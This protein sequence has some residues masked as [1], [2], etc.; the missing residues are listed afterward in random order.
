[1]ARSR[2]TGFTLLEVLVA[3]S[4]LAALSLALTQAMAA[5]H[6][7]TYAALEQAR[8]ITLVE[9]MHEEIAAQPFPSNPLAVLPLPA[10]R[11]L[12][13]DLKAYDNLTEIPGALADHHGNLLPET[14]QGFTRSVLIAENA[15]CTINDLGV[16]L[17]GIEV[18]VT[19]ALPN[20][21]SWSTTRFIPNPTGAL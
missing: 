5:G 20:G 16:T 18:T 12:I 15:T 3:M 6:M 8:A 13:T 4:I 19:V 7:Q 10:I 14:Y 1:M 9:S 2:R 11:S 21:Q 17:T